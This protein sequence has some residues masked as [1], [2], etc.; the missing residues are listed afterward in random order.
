M[1]NI[2]YPG[3]LWFFLKGKILIIIQPVLYQ[4]ETMETLWHLH[5]IKFSTQDVGKI[6]NSVFFLG[7]L[8]STSLDIFHRKHVRQDQGVG[9]FESFQIL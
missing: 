3:R 9:L 1:Y 4:S 6:L 5:M 8:F 7:T 2:T